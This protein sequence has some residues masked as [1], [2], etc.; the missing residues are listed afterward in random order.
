M[1]V[2]GGYGSLFSLTN[3]HFHHNKI[4]IASSHDFPARIRLSLSNMMPFQHSAK[5]LLSH[6]TKHQHAK[7]SPSRSLT[8][9]HARSYARTSR[10]QE[11]Q[12]SPTSSNTP[13]QS[14]N[15]SLPSF[16]I[17]HQIRE[18]RPAVRYT[19]YAGLGLM[20]TV[21]STFWF[22]VIRA[23]FFPSTSEEQQRKNEEF[24]WRLRSAIKSAR[25]VY[26]RN[27][28]RYYGAYLWGLGYGGLDESDVGVD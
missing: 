4:T 17:F 24:L 27:Y 2:Y 14:E 22:Q 25:M 8:V 9:H 15:P 21:E 5:P 11:K 7:T 13:H 28:G 23:K 10:L 1:E 19:V 6:I 26:I 20:A 3:Y 12:H 16:N 18:A